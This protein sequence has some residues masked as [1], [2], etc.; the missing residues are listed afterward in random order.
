MAG[1]DP[2]ALAAVTRKRIVWPS[3]D[4][5]SMYWRP[6][7]PLIGSQPFPAVLQRSQA[8]A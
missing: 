1:V 7:A 2:S 4:E 5:A 8:Y 3:S 6:V